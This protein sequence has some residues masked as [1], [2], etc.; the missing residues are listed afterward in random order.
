[1]TL[2]DGGSSGG[3][4]GWMMQRRRRKIINLFGLVLTELQ[5]NQTE[6]VWLSHKKKTELV[7]SSHFGYQL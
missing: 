2:R 3:W 1:M 7:W 4:W 6:L 5:Q